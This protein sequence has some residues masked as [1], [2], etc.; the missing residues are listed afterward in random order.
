[1]NV[2]KFAGKALMGMGLFLMLIG[3]T[4]VPSVFAGPVV[5]NAC[6]GTCNNCGKAESQTT[7]G[8]ICVSKDKNRSVLG[9]CKTGGGP[10]SACNRCKGDCQVIQVGGNDTCTCSL[11]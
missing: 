11:N 7:G 3:T 8:P 10:R 6:A 1:M 9:T 4:S 2:K 5:V